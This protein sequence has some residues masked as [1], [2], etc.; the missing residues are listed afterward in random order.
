MRNTQ[1]HYGIRAD[2][3]RDTL[4]ITMSRSGLRPTTVAQVNR[5]CL[6]VA[7][8]V[9]RDSAGV[10]G[11]IPCP[12]SSNRGSDVTDDL[13][14]DPD[15]LRSGADNSLG[16]VISLTTHVPGLPSAG[17]PSHAGVSAVDAA[18]SSVRGL[19]AGRVS[20]QANDMSTGS[21]RY[22]GTDGQSAGSLTE[23]V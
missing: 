13:E 20:E 1:E 22:E 2:V 10:A 17:P 12:C 18:V 5:G 4:A 7:A 19:Q 23:S 8:E 21:N 6:C 11:V 9:R 3:G 15:G 16:V 14:V